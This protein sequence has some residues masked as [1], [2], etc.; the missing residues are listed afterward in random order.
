MTAA[1]T[2]DATTTVNESSRDA[3]RPTRLFLYWS[4]KEEDRI[5]R[6]NAKRET[7]LDVKPVQLSE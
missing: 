1:K 3:S 5:G 2:G 6:R 7:Y 4:D